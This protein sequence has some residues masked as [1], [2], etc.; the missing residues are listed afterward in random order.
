LLIFG[1]LAAFFISENCALDNHTCQQEN[2]K[3]KPIPLKLE[4]LHYQ[5]RARQGGEGDDR[6]IKKEAD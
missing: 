3:Y 5:G 4:S 6:P 1:W 2:K